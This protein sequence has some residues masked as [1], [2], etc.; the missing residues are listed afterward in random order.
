MFFYLTRYLAVKVLVLILAWL[1][2]EH[3]LT[4][5]YIFLNEAFTGIHQAVF[6]RWNN[7]TL[8]ENCQIYWCH[9]DTTNLHQF[10]DGANV[11]EEWYVLSSQSVHVLQLYQAPDSDLS[12]ISTV[13]C[14]M[15]TSFPS[16][17]Q[18]VRAPTYSFWVLTFHLITDCCS[19]ARATS[20][21]IM[22]VR[23]RSSNFIFDGST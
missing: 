16:R 4:A 1:L 12:F 22:L 14:S 19:F 21:T 2:L 7:N 23:I 3:Y 11:G 17:I 10:L 9:L 6:N 18:S 5:L 8:I 15:R 20:I 13:K